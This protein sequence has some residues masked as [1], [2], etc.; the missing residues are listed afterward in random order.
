V[1]TWIA[2]WSETRP[3]PG[4]ATA[5]GSWVPL[6]WDK[7]RH[8]LAEHLDRSLKRWSDGDTRLDYETA[9]AQIKA[10]DEPSGPG[11]VWKL[12]D[13]ELSLTRRK[14]HDA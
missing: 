1:N 13:H 9:L 12:R 11:L 2:S 10:A 6:P 7:A 8:K 4:Q 3:I 14:E 5:S